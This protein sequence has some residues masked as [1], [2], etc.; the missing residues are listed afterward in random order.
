MR[1][2]KI[3]AAA[4]A[5]AMPGMAMAAT[6]GTLGATSTGTMNVSLTVGPNTTDFVQILGLDDIA[7][8]GFVAGF[9]GTSDG[10][11]SYFCLNKNTLGNVKLTAD[12]PNVGFSPGEY[13]SQLGNE[14]MLELRLLSPVNGFTP[15]SGDGWAF[16]PAT[17]P[18]ACNAS[19][20]SGVAYTF[21]AKLRTG[22]LP[23]LEG[24]YSNTLTLTLAPE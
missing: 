22:A 17:D 6:D 16:L 7:F 1:S 14:A 24:T 11:L 13:A 2:L 20:G 23:L 18:N 12:K 21:Q 4:M 19:S 9:T 5:L 15:F 3:A 10:Q 8:T